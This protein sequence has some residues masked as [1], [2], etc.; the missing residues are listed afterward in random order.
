MTW[1]NSLITQVWK[2]RHW[3]LSNLTRNPI[4]I[5]TELTLTKGSPLQLCNLTL[6]SV[7]KIS[8]GCFA[9]EMEGKCCPLI[10]TFLGACAQLQK[11]IDFPKHS[12]WRWQ[13]Y[14]FKCCWRL[15]WITAEPKDLSWRLPF[16]E[17]SWQMSVHAKHQRTL[18]TL[19][20]PY[21]KPSREKEL[22]CFVE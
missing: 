22:G 6:A 16:M 3:A 12:P 21:S 5:R 7:L 14:F 4:L 17:L 9:F 10:F 20:A 19:P 15:K 18:S 8:P 2:L 11:I 13:F 1:Y